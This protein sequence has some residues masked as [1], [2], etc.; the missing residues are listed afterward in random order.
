MKSPNDP[1]KQCR[2][3]EILAALYDTGK[4]SNT[5]WALNLKRLPGEPEGN[6][7][8]VATGLMVDL[9]LAK[10]AE[11]WKL[12]K[13]QRKEDVWEH[14]WLECEGWAIDGSNSFPHP[15]EPGNYFIL[16]DDANHYRNVR[17]I[18]EI[19]NVQDD[20]NFFEDL[21]RSVVDHF[22]TIP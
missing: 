4:L 19:L 15:Q 12:I 10:S 11:G 13:G 21:Y 9:I 17:Q 8:E 5:L 20:Q 2:P 7:L 18:S 6:C 3:S 16:I 1:E 14:W 22:Q